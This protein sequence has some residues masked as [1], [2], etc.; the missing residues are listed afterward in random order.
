MNVFTEDDLIITAIRHAA[1]AGGLRRWAA[2]DERLSQG[3]ARAAA[4]QS[5]KSRDALDTWVES[6]IG[7]L[8]EA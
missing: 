4:R 1:L 8:G 2:R 3:F 5:E 6:E 7:P